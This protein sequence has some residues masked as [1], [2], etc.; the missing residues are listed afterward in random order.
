MKL[1]TSELLSY[2]TVRI[3][4]EYNDGA[5][6]TGTGFI[7]NFL[8]DKEKNTVVP[9]VITNKHVVKDAIRGKFVFTIATTNQEPSDTDH[10]VTEYEDFESLWIMHPNDDVDLCALSIVPLILS[11]RA[12]GI[13]I[14]Y[15]ALSKDLLP[16]EKTYDSINALEEIVMIGY[17]NGLWDEVNNKPIFRKGITASHPKFDYCGKK[18][19]IIDAACFPGSSGSPVLIFNE[20]AWKVKGNDH[21]MGGT[22]LILMGVLY[23]GP[24][25]TADGEIVVIDVPTV[26]KSIFVPHN[27]LN[28][29]YVIKAERILELE[30]L[31]KSA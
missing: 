13:N 10:Y 1:S 25:Y 22:R 6:G 8:E 31:F 26:Q 30:E 11:A 18:E 15:W 7:F 5:I 24:Q 12:Q 29:G 4:C 14:F 27:L 21:I 23:A 19:M 2:S 3:S 16:D 20:G 9:V 28:L 17:P